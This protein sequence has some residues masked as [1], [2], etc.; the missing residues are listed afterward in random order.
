MQLKNKINPKGKL[1]ND[2][3]V[4]SRVVLAGYIYADLQRCEKDHIHGVTQEVS[5]GPV[6]LIVAII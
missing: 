4:A 1:N 6:E 3:E 5:D 2:N